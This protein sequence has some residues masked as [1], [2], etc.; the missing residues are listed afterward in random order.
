M[1]ICYDRFVSLDIVLAVI[2][3][4]IKHIKV[5]RHWGMMANGCIMVVNNLV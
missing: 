5:G 3:A 4:K 1:H 2:I